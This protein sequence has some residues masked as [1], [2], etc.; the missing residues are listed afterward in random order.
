MTECRQA[1]R[2]SG[3]NPAITTRKME[4]FP[5]ERSIYWLW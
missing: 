2:E 1:P 5:S 3:Q 4:L